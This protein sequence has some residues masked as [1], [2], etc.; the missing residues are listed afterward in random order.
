MKLNAECL[1]YNIA[2]LEQRRNVS[3]EIIKQVVTLL[4]LGVVSFIKSRTSAIPLPPDH[5]VPPYT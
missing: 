1:L 4:R 5:A 3:H 2:L